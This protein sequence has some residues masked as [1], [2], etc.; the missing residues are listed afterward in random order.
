MKPFLS[1]LENT[2]LVFHQNNQIFPTTCMSSN[3]FVTAQ[4]MKFSIT[5]FFSKC[6]QIRRKLRTWS[7][8][9]KK[10]V[11]EKF[12]FCVVCLKCSSSFTSIWW[13]S[14]DDINIYLEKLDIFIRWSKWFPDYIFTT[15]YNCHHMFT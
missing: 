2:T 12:I 13:I 14:S 5:D 6:D 4:K 3:S 15:S 11:M 8:L 7:H 1:F 10:S 9:L